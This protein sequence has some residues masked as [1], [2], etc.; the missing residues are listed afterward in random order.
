MR[1]IGADRRQ[2]QKA[3]MAAINFAI[4]LYST[5]LAFAVLYA[6]HLRCR[7]RRRIWPSAGRPPRC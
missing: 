6:P 3:R 1:R 2:Y 4:I 7:R 5:V